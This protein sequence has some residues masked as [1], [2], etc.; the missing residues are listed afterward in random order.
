MGDSFRECF[1][2]LTLNTL[3]TTLS[4]D[5]LSNGKNDSTRALMFAVVG[6]KAPP[7]PL[8]VL[9]V[10]TLPP[11]VLKTSFAALPL[12]T[13]VM[14]MLCSMVAGGGVCCWLAWLMGGVEV[15]L[16]LLLLTIPLSWPQPA[17][18]WV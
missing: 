2:S 3:Y 16:L 14:N 13:H 7:P 6:T 10:S 4:R 9:L 5:D 15:L 1:I 18:G 12:A 17:G 8:L 11:T